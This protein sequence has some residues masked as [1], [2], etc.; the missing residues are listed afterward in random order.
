[1]RDVLVVDDGFQI[2]LNAAYGSFQLVGDVLRELPFQAYLFFFQSDVV[3]GD[4]KTQVLEDDT[5]YNE[6]ASV[7]INIDG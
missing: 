3:D 5:F 1:M 7:F 4:F 6:Y 2:P